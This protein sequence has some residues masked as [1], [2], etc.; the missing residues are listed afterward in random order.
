VADG[1]MRAYRESGTDLTGV[2]ARVP[3]GRGLKRKQFKISK[4]NIRAYVA[5]CTYLWGR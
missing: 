3:G 2:Y 5:S 4:E 1:E